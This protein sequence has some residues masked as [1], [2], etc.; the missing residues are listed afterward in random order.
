MSADT[1]KIQM[2]AGGLSP[3]EN[4]AKFRSN[5][6]AE[7]YLHLRAEGRIWEFGDLLQALLRGSR[8]P[9]CRVLEV[10]LYCD[11]GDGKDPLIKLTEAIEEDW[12]VAETNEETSFALLEIFTTIVLDSMCHSEDIG[13][14]NTIFEFSRKKAL[15][16]LEFNP[17][18]S[19]SRPYLRWIIS[20]VLLEQYSNPRI[21][22]FF[23]LKQ[24]LHNLPGHR[25]APNLSDLPKLCMI[26]YAPDEDEAPRWS[27]DPTT[28]IGHDEALRTVLSVAEELGDV[29]LQATCLQLLI[30]QSPEPRTLLRSLDDLWRAAGTHQR[31]LETRLYCYIPEALRS[32]EDR[33]GLQRQILLSAK[34]SSQGLKPYAEYMILR[35][36]TPRLEEKDSYLE[37]AM[38]A[39]NSSFQ[40]YVPQSH[41]QTPT[42][43]PSTRKTTGHDWTNGNVS[44]PPGGPWQNLPPESSGGANYVGAQYPHMGYAPAH[45][46]TYAA[47]IH[48]FQEMRTTANPG[49]MGNSANAPY[50]TSKDRFGWTG[51]A[52]SGPFSQYQT[53]FG[54]PYAQNQFPH[55]QPPPPPPPSPPPTKPSAPG[56]NFNRGRQHA[57]R[58]GAKTK[59]NNSG[60]PDQANNQAGSDN[61][62]QNEPA[63]TS[64]SDQ[65]DILEVSDVT[66]EL[67]LNRH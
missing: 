48:P 15:D 10:L 27:P 9:V 38:D 57:C 63:D 52:Q 42:E 24:C 18:N 34:A 1:K 64:S 54:T 65:S 43:N 58:P 44:A 67:Y 66:S 6:I 36:L 2:L 47:D 26:S 7:V 33:A 45:G 23:S 39:L 19:K 56:P 37:R 51:G 59:L 61:R 5:E 46:Y 49:Y 62:K 11:L 14:V 3:K 13:L 29:W 55:Y 60:S 53:N 8:E 31:H 32:A 25:I 17:T 28:T 35:A 16:V 30:Y 21:T 41:N 12:S 4:I 40:G 20:K 50:V 22:G